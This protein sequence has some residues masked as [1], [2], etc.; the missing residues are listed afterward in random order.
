[1]CKN[2]EKFLLP[3]HFLLLKR[4]AL[5]AN[6]KPFSHRSIHSTDFE[7]INC[8]YIATEIQNGLVR[9]SKVAHLEYLSHH[10]NQA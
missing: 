7:Q 6:N 3:R 5:P 4:M 9:P 8:R 1:M 10:V 2:R